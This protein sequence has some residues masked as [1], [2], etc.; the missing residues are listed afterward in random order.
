MTRAVEVAFPTDCIDEDWRRRTSV[1]CARRPN[2]L[3]LAGER[4]SVRHDSAE[5]FTEAEG[6]QASRPKT[7]GGP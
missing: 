3:D 2:A 4:E 6:L 5:P 1:V 7:E